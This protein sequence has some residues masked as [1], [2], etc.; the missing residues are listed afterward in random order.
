MADEMKAMAANNIWSMVPLSPNKHT[1]YWVSLMY[2][3][4]VKY[5]ANGTVD[6]YKARLVAEDYTQQTILDL[7]LILFPL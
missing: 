4:K 1:I 2:M 5:K 7:V 6:G 3:C